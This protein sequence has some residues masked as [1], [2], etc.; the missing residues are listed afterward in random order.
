MLITWITIR[1]HCIDIRLIRLLNS[2]RNNGHFCFIQMYVAVFLQ[3]I[4]I[5]RSN[6][7][8]RHQWINMASTLPP[9]WRYITGIQYVVF[10][11]HFIEIVLI[12]WYMWQI[13]VYAVWCRSLNFCSFF[14]HWL[15]DYVSLFFVHVWLRTRYV[16]GLEFVCI[17][18]GFWA[19]FLHQLLKSVDIGRVVHT[20]PTEYVVSVELRYVKI[21]Q[22]NSFPQLMVF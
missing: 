14:M 1:M 2:I 17:P 6:I 7:I 18:V 3:I 22:I 20:R 12:V 8:L 15:T 4:S 9:T 10:L 19:L 11:L 16:M 13:L 5:S 21:A